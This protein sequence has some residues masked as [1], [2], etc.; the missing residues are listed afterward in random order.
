[1]N[2]SGLLQ[3]DRENEQIREGNL[4]IGTTVFLAGFAGILSIILV[5]TFSAA[6]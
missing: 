2:I 3:A 4:I 1:M 5:L 6:L